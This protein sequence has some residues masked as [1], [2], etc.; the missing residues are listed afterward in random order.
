MLN[1]TTNMQDSEKDTENKKKTD[2]FDEIIKILEEYDNGNPP[3]KI[4]DYEE[5]CCR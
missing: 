4:D 3:R 2:P 1:I 5:G